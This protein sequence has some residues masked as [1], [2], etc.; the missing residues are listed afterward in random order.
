M[1]LT[2]DEG[3]DVVLNSL[4]DAFIAKSFAVLRP[5]GRFI[6]IGRRGI[7]SKEQAAHLRP[8]V[9]YEAFDLA[10]IMNN[11]PE[12]LRPMFEQILSDCAA[13]RLQPLPGT[14]FPMEAVV[15]ALRFMQQARHI[16][17]IVIQQP[18]WAGGR[19][20][21]APDAFEGQSTYLVTGAFGGIGLGLT[22]WLFERGA[23][24][25][26]LVGRG[27]PS[28]AVMARIAELEPA[29]SATASARAGRTKANRLPT[30][31]RKGWRRCRRCAAFSTWPAPWM[32]AP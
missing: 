6:E 10:A 26:A 31:S 24:H 15:G 30:S 8:D 21:D 16:G 1:E 3:V 22:R 5:N 12:V 13:G 4:S 23:R 32:T 2:R 7:L 20:I 11:S 29:P 25:F 9:F 17:K 18:K 27:Q 28:E 19:S 14:I